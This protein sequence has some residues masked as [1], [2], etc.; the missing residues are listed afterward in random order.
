MHEKVHD[1]VSG[2]FGQ[3][4][5]HRHYHWQWY[6]PRYER[7]LERVRFNRQLAF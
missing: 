6:E 2:I 4:R 1:A 5:G 7:N 3:F